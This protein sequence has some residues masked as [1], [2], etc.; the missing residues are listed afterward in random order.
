MKITITPDSEDERAALGGK[1]SIVIEGA[2]SYA[3]TGTR[4]EEGSQPI[5]LWHGLSHELIG[6]LEGLKF[7]IQ[8]NDFMQTM[9]AVASQPQIINPNHPVQQHLNRMKFPS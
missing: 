7:L 2:K 1:E 3:I 5:N 8:K 4:V 6:G 9:K